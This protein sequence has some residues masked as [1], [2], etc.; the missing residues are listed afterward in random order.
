MSNPTFLA[1]PDNLAA[2][3]TLSQ[4]SASAAYPAS[5][6]Q[7]LPVS[8]PYRTTGI[9]SSEYV[10]F[11]LGSAQAI[12]LVAI[13]NHNFSSG[14]TITIK[15]GASA[16]PSTFTQVMTY[17]QYDMF[18]VISQTYRYWRITFNDTGNTNAYLSLGYV[19]IGN[20]TAMAFNYGYDFP[21]VDSYT[22]LE[23]QTEF[24]VPH[25][26]PLA[27][28]VAMSHTFNNLSRCEHGDSPGIVHQV[29]EERLSGVLDSRYLR[30]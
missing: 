18:T 26:A 3:A 10:E 23:A 8:K 20:A 9:T 29:P 15:G 19:M 24:N 13:L 11:D 25:I 5:N 12:T 14:A 28:Q 27:Y 4:F 2:T 22:N 30:E 17:R 16:N 6:L 7:A 1:T 21:F